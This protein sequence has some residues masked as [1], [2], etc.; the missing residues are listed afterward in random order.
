MKEKNEVDIEG[1]LMGVNRDNER[2]WVM[3]KVGGVMT[4]LVVSEEEDLVGEEG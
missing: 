1:L 2:I 3:E 4:E